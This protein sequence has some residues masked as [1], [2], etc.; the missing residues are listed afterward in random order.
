M[1]NFIH[2]LE[3]LFGLQYPLLSQASNSTIMKRQLAIQYALAVLL[4]GVAAAFI[5]FLTIRVSQQPLRK[6]A[7][8]SQFQSLIKDFEILT[9]ELTGDGKEINELTGLAETTIQEYEKISADAGLDVYNVLSKLR[10]ETDH[11]AAASES[12]EKQLSNVSDSTGELKS[13]YASLISHSQ[14]IMLKDLKQIQTLLEVY[15]QSLESNIQKTVIYPTL[16]ALLL[17]GIFFGLAWLIYKKV[18]TFE[19]LRDSIEEKLQKEVKRVATVNQ[20]VEAIVEERYSE[21]ITFE[22]GDPLAE[23]LLQMKSKLLTSAEEDRKRNWATQGMAKI[24]TLLRD[25]SDLEKLYTNITQFCAKYTNSNQAAL[26]VTNDEN[27]SHPR[28]D[29]VSAYAYDKRKF[30]TKTIEFGEGLVGQ[31][32]LEG[33]TVFM[34]HLP[35]NYIHITSGLGGATPNALVIVPL[36]FNDKIFGVL[37]MASFKPYEEFEIQFLEM[38]G[39]SVAAAISTAKVNNQTK[40]LLEKSQQQAEELRAQEEEVRQNMEELSATQEHMSRQMKEIKILAEDLQVRED[41]FAL[42]TIL[43]EADLFGT[44]TLANNKLVE[45]S[46]YSREELI[47]KPHSIFRHQDMPRELFKLFWDT[48]KR[49]DVFRGI[50]KNRAK[51]GTHYWVDATIVPVKDGSGRIVKYIGARYHITDDSFAEH[52][53][54]KQAER[55]HMPPLKSTPRAA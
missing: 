24:G 55:L 14:G 22:K 36:K 7:A 26:F 45:V 28:L 10:A 8:V 50:I 21:D 34:T 35:P 51:D 5:S 44:I 17:C 1:T 4:L 48:I 32:V 43:S 27:E 42:T 9:Q 29:L 2:R 53:Y 20:F 52:L 38:L 47:G 30:I 31:V 41:V 46:K 15:Q 11:I 16:F 33:K 39:E 3:Q 40:M 49:G 23:R 6:L 12:F 18:G 25:A 13:N 37:E 19:N 54:N